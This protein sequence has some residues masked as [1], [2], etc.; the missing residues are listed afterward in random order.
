M[1]IDTV[2]SQGISQCPR[3]H[4]TACF[5]VGMMISFEGFEDAAPCKSDGYLKHLGLCLPPP[6]R[7]PVLSL[8]TTSC[9]QC[10]HHPDRHLLP[11]QKLRRMP[12]PQRLHQL[13]LISLFNTIFPLFKSPSINRVLLTA[14]PFL[15]WIPISLHRFLKERF[16]SWKIYSIFL[17]TFHGNIM[18]NN[19]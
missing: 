8:S 4:S 5:S 11:L 7:F 9:R 14:L 15:T 6:T 19:L 13:P 2:I 12:R 18:Y 3:S 16:Q 10:L 1:E 17:P